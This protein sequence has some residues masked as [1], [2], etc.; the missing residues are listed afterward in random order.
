MTTHTFTVNGT[1]CKECLSSVHLSSLSFYLTAAHEWGEVKRE[2][3]KSR[4]LFVCF[5]HVISFTYL[6][7]QMMI[8]LNS[9]RGIISMAGV[10]CQS[11][12]VLV[13]FLS[14]LL[15]GVFGVHKQLQSAT[16]RGRC[17]IT[18]ICL[19]LCVRCISCACLLIKMSSQSK[20]FARGI[21][22][23]LFSIII[24]ILFLFFVFFAAQMRNNMRHALHLFFFFLSS[25]SSISGVG[26]NLF[27]FCFFSRCT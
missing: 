4:Q 16:S 10:Y 19:S 21:S 12:C 11:R 13:L 14:T 15:T 26:L 20:C 18:N 9:G 24:F 17:P 23:Y 1:I 3:R 7:F 22:Q 25:V 2:E 27:L 8:S 6:V 5:F